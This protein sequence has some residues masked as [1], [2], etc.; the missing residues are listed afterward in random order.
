MWNKGNY[1]RFM[2][3]RRGFIK[4]TRA[5]WNFNPQANLRTLEL[6]GELNRHFEASNSGKR[7]KSSL[8]RSDAAGSASFSKK[9]ERSMLMSHR[10]VTVN[11]STKTPFNPVYNPRYAPTPTGS[12]AP[13]NTLSSSPEAQK[14]ATP[15]R[16]RSSWIEARARELAELQAALKTIR[17]TPRSNTTRKTRMSEGSLRVAVRTAP[18]TG[19][20]RKAS[21]LSTTTPPNTQTGAT[22]SSNPPSTGTLAQD[23]IKKPGKSHRAP[24]RLGLSNEQPSSRQKEEK[25]ASATVGTPAPT[26]SLVKQRG[27]R[28]IDAHISRMRRASE[29]KAA[30][31]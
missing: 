2:N 6:I 20:K 8:E 5:L 28:A 24:S 23:V 16:R 9:Q 22:A 15:E 10:S 30:R 25:Q 14:L 31:R 26:K 4:E 21:M 11:P 12:L 27:N 3:S 7:R 19:S 13:G 29:K 18:L 1:M 17:A